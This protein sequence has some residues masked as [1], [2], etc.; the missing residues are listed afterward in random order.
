MKQKIIITKSEAGERLDLILAKRMPEYS[1]NFFANLIKT[2]EVK[3]LRQ[4]L[5]PSFCPKAGEQFEISLTPPELESLPEPEKIDLNI[6]YEDENVIVIN[7]SAGLVVHPA[8]GNKTG[9]LVNALLAHTPGIREAVSNEDKLVSHFRPGIVHRLDKDTT[10]VMIVAK[11]PR[12]MHS[13]SRQIMNRNVKK[14]YLAICCG[15]LK[16]SFG[17]LTNSIGR[18]QKNRK[19]MAEVGETI[20]KIAISD[21]IVRKN[22]TDSK[23]NKF[24]LVEFDIKTGRTHQIRL[25]S[26]LIG[27]PILGDIVYGNRD[28]LKF[29]KTLQVERQMLHAQKLTLTLPGD[30]KS[31][32]FEAPLPKD[33]LSV[34][35]KLETVQ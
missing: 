17:K 27:K 7:K 24:S 5:K 20:G 12:A 9:T 26:K 15:W 4:N 33:F 18:S 2:G 14:V 13:L 19:I 22:F 35:D 25:Q 34:L 32:T 31:T 16:E 10:G 23:G 21:Y 3:S 28:S 29:S 11:N 30:D 1:R 8:A 6:L